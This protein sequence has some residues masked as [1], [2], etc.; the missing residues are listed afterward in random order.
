M[1]EE[2][3]AGADVG[4]AGDVADVGGEAF[5]WGGLIP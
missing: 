4:K 1:D 2:D 3:V 5:G